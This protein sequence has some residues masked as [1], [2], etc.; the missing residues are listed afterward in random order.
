VALVRFISERKSRF[1]AGPICRV[2]TQHG[3]TIAPSTY[4]GAARRAPSARAV[5]DEQLKAAISRVHQDNF[6]VYGAR[7]V[8]LALNREGMP[9]A[10]CTVERLMRDLGLHGARRGRRARTT[11]PAAAA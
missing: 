10:L 9:V 6:G 8:W 5:R 3:C 1:G 4:Y 7:K 2:L 11:V